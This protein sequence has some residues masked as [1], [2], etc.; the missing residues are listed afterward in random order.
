[1][2]G[3]QGRGDGVPSSF[4]EVPG[5][6]VTRQGDEDHPVVLWNLS[7]GARVVAGAQHAFNIVGHLRDPE[8]ALSYRLN[9]GPEQPVHVRRER[10]GASRVQRVGDFSID[11]IPCRELADDNDLA[12]TVRRPGREPSTR[13]VH[14]G[15]RPVPESF[16]GL[17]RVEADRAEELG[18]V[19]DGR[20]RLETEDGR[21]TLRIRAGDAGYD[22]IILLAVPRPPDYEVYARF[23]VDRWLSRY[24][25]VGLVFDWH[26]HPPGD[27]THL[28][29]EWTTGLAYYASTGRGLKLRIGAGVR[30]LP[31]GGRLGSAVVD[32]ST[33]SRWRNLATRALAAVRL[34]RWYLPQLRAGVTHQIRLQ[35][36]GGE[37]AVSVWSDGE[38]PR[39][40]ITAAVPRLLHPGAAGL[41]AF[42]CALRVHDFRVTPM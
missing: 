14:F 16:P 40:R 1:M 3:G 35:V 39:P 33:V 38:E 28:P 15:I 34:G 41:I 17:A 29:R 25:N 12:L 24:H 42:N 6:A 23:T 2:Q 8:A 20:W 5:N 21:P 26:G 11:T 37:H 13:V 22:R 32:E 18:Q 4:A 36:H 10:R 31:N 7:D 27:G 30:V 9:D 19:V